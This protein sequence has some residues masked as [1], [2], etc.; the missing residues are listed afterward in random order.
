MN[1]TQKVFLSIVFVA[2][3]TAFSDTLKTD[4]GFYYPADMKHSSSPYFGYGDKNSGLNNRCHVANDYKLSKG[5]PVYA[6]GSGVVEAAG[7]NIPFYGSDTGASGGVIVIKHTT[8][9]NKIFYG[10]Y[11]HIDSFKVS[12]GDTVKGGQ[13][14]AEVGSYTS[15]GQSLTHL[16]FGINSALPTLGNGRYEGYTPTAA[17]SNYFGYVDPEDY[18]ET[19]SAKV[20]AAE[21]CKAN[22]DTVST[23]KNSIVTTD[24]VLSNDTDTNGDTLSVAA[25]DATSKNGVTITNNSDGTFTYTPAIDFT[26]SDS[27]DYTVTDNNGCTDTAKVSITV[28]AKDSGGSSSSGGGS[29]NLLSLFGSFSFLLLSVF[30]RGEK[31]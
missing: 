1:N 31:H 11:G 12:K 2:P 28:N 10:F 26:G 27:F 24:N 7:L 30:R 22:D 25:V 21:T 14:I 15:Q 17:C 9:E 23:T 4:T 13:Q 3:I 18:L 16:H 8:E 5:T 6:A 20:T 29:F 19:N